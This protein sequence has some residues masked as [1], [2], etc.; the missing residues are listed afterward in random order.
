MS[1]TSCN[2]PRQKFIGELDWRVVLIGYRDRVPDKHAPIRG[3]R[4]KYQA[5]IPAD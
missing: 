3:D 2:P 5:R 1:V 4:G